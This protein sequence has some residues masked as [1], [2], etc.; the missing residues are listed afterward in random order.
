MKKLLSTLLIA[1]LAASASAAT[2]VWTNAAGGSWHVATNW[3]NG[4]PGTFDNAYITNA[5][6]YTV[7]MSNSVTINALTVGGFGTPTLMLDKNPTLSVANGVIQ[8]G[9]TM[10]LSNCWMTGALTIKPGAQLF[11]NAPNNITIYTFALTNQ[12]TVTWNSGTLG[13]GGTT[14]HNS[15]LWT[16][17]GNVT[18]GHGGG[19][20][21]TWINS[22]TLR[23][24]AGAGVASIN[25]FN[26]LGQPGGVVEV[27]TGTLTFANG[28]ANVLQGLFT[29][30]PG[31][32]FNFV[33]G[34][35][36]DC[37]TGIAGPGG[38]TFNSGIFNLR[39]NV[40]AGLKFLGGEVWITGG[41]SF[42]QAGAITNL[43][44]DGATLRGTNLVGAGTLT[45][46]S[47]SLAEK[48]T[49]SPAGQLVIAPGGNKLFYSSILVNQGTVTCNSPFSVGGNS[50]SNGGLW[51]V[52]GDFNAGNGG[53]GIA[54]WTNAGI[55]R[56]T[57]GSGLAQVDGTFVNLPGATVE[58]QSGRLVL[59][60][61][62]ASVF[63]GTFNA[64]GFIELDKGPWTDA[65]GVGIGSGTNRLVNLGVF[66]LRTN[67]PAG[68]QFAGGTVNITSTNTFQNAGAIT[69]LTLDGA[70][71]NG[72]NTVSGGTLTL[73]AGTITGKL[74]VQPDG[75]LLFA[76]AISKFIYPLELANR[77]NVTM[78]GTSISVGN[79]TVSNGGA[80]IIPGDFSFTYSGV[81]TPIFTNAGL[82]HKSAGSTTTF[83]SAF[84]FYNQTNGIVQVSSGALQLNA[85]FTNYAGTL[86]LN[87]GQLNASGTFA[88]AGGTLDGAGAFGANAFTG[89]TISP[90]TAGPGAIAF[91]SGLN[92]NSN[93]TFVVEGNGP[94]P[95]TMFDQLSVTGAVNLANCALQ[96]SSLPS[97]PA[98]TTFRI[99]DNDGS[100]AVSGTFAG[101][102]ENSAITVGAQTFRI[103]YAAGTGNDVTLVRDG[104][105]VGPLLAMGGFTNGSWSFSGSGAIPL[106]VFTVRASTNLVNWTN[107]GFTTS[108]V[109]GVIN[110]VDTN[111]W[112]YSRRFYNTTN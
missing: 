99:I 44:I 47:G 94:I 53:L 35:W 49:I 85:N 112:R 104:V 39:T 32:L 55:F 54:N 79:T 13:I 92:L 6:S 81:G 29:N 4:L 58:S 68:L 5:G 97:G 14:I 80:W 9:A 45:M 103:H 71:L 64:T 89:G 95:G 108:S 93:V 106:T 2:C 56:K 51:Q 91:A 46:T 31:A 26:F 40:P 78:S 1:A 105:V 60:N 34:T 96:V 101:L 43:T 62:T 75:Q 3:L 12:G 77:G 16:I 67:V 25:D 42:Q 33:G 20:A 61:G 100:D 88:V 48:L 23:R 86:R 24:V 111:A 15:G 17:G 27:Q 76:T 70:T 73:N 28:T 90:G 11:G 52:T 74:T 50:V 59:A 38:N 18:S 7:V 63:G 69:N 22:G 109:S 10:Q 36:T 37:G 21:S 84:G 82:L 8:S 83:C 57:G 66:N 110:F 41:N 102:P 87:G 72:T 98:G 65:G 19:G 107:I 30:A